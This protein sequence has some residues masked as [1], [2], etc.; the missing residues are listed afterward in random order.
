M[1]KVGIIGSGTIALTHLDAYKECHDV[2]VVA[3]ADL[4]EAL[5][6]KTASK[7]QI[8]EVYKDY[9]ELLQKEEIEAVNIATPLFTHAQIV[10]DALLAGKH[11]LCEKPPCLTAAEAEE[12]VQVARETGKL[13]MWGFVCRFRKEIRFLKEYV[14]AGQMGKI[15]YAEACRINR[16]Q[17]S[18]GWFLDKKKA[19][20][21]ALF[22]GAVH[23][24]DELLYLMGYPKA[25]VVS[26]FAT[27]CNKELPE[28][29]K[30]ASPGWKSAD[31]G[32]YERTIESMANGHIL[33]ENGA[34]L[35]IKAAYSAFSVT[36]GTYLEVIGEKAGARMEGDQLTLLSNCNDYFLE[37]SPVLKEKADLFTQ[38]MQHF[39]DCCLN[40]E[41]CICEAWQG[42]ELVRILEAIYRAAETGTPVIL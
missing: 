11:V 14:D 32:H 13:L 6:A 20:G 10:K 28:K 40:K 19:G 7:Y 34:S 39:I 38:E 16:C 21:G 26:G 5:A 27:D 31:T 24:L 41:E 42:V 9:H 17:K 1:L 30:S 3:I 29:M 12:C 15:Y 25:T 18:S 33:F 35:Y 2:Q 23:E 4:N 37:S 36:Q 8:A 22:D